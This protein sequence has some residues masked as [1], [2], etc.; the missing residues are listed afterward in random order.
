MRTQ[1]S[2]HPPGPAAA[3]PIDLSRLS[4]R[5]KQIVR[6][7][8]NGDRVPRIAA[9]LFLAQSTVRNHLS[10]V[11]RKFGIHSQQE[12]IELLRGGVE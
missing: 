1:P 4:E 9:S 11:F 2:A 7:L 5:E 10:I 3:A 12:L 8:L 6:L